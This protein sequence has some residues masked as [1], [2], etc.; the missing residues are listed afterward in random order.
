VVF[1]LGLVAIVL[2]ATQVSPELSVLAAG[3]MFALAALVTGGLLGFLFGIPRTLTSDGQGSEGRLA[4][5]QGIRA[6]TNLE[7]ISDWLTKILVGIT[8]V[9]LPAIQSGAVRLFDAMEPSLGGSPVGAPFAG[10]IVIYFATVG[11]LSGWLT[12]RLRLGQAMDEADR[13]IVLLKEAQVAEA[14]GDTEAARLYRSE[15]AA[16]LERAGPAAGS[17]RDLRRRMPSGPARTAEMETLIDR[18][19]GMAVDFSPEEVHSIFMQGDDGMRLV[20]L[21]LMEG[22][23]RLADFEI[24]REA[25]TNSKSAFEQYHGLAAAYKMIP[26]LT[27]DQRAELARAIAQQR[28]GNG[29][30]APGSDRWELS[31]A[32]LQQLD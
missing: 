4:A 29:H 10:G 21:A 2:F 23:P 5:L 15:A 12:T 6:N 20:A 11:F 25:V 8:L 31:E 32:I 9:Q 13:A 22:N 16:A 30:I 17:Y 24:I 27:S 3:L 7:Q 14:A 26:A 1:L 28:Q 18:I 19:K